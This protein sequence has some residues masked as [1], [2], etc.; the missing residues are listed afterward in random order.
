[1]MKKLK[2]F[3]NRWSGTLYLAFVDCLITMLAGGLAMLV[4]FEFSFNR[5][6]DEILAEWYRFIP[7]EL[8][9]TI[10]LFAV[11]G[12]YSYVLETLSALD[13]SKIALSCLV[14]SLS[15]GVVAAIMGVKLSVSIW[16]MMMSFKAVGCTSVRY[17]SR[18]SESLVS[19]IGIHREESPTRIMLV[20]AGAAGSNIMREIKSSNRQL[21]TVVCVIDDDPA[22]VGKEFYG[23][24]IVGGREAII[25]SSEKYKVDEIFIAVPSASRSER[26][27]LLSICNQTSC[28]V[29]T[30]P[31]IYQFINNEISIAALRDVSIQ[32]LLG[33]DQVELD[34]SEIYGFISGKKVVV[35]GAGGSIGS[36]LCRQIAQYDPNVLI[37]IDIYENSLYDIQQELK[38]TYGD[39][40]DFRA[41]IASIRDKDRIYSLFEEYSPDIVFHA[42]AHKHV[43]LMENAPEEAIKNNVFGTYHVVRAAEKF[44]VS[45]FI[46]I[47]TDKAVNPTN[48]MGATKRFC[49]MVLQSRQNSTTE[50]AS[51][52]FGNVLGSNGSVVPLF[53]K[54]IEE[55]GPV[56]ITDKRII[57]YFM[58]IPE[59]CS[60]VLEAGAMAKRNQVFILDMGDPVKIIDLAEEMIRLAGLRP[61]IDIPIVEIGL[62]PGEKLYEELLMS[63]DNLTKTANSKIFIEEQE[64]LSQDFIMSCL[65]EL[66]N[67]LENGVN[68][69]EAIALLMR[70]IPTYQPP[71]IVNSKVVLS[72][73]P[74]GQAHA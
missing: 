66:D 29:K 59:A 32:D 16:F 64:P 19:A 40:L 73:V 21:G 17:S 74:G 70:I 51:V 41:E 18:I 44:G 42:A 23:V 43:P 24:R 39:N 15:V 37:G 28:R 57:R 52:R 13:I 3:Y 1:M 47:S 36:E 67:A 27:E 48:I 54:Q 38:R 62:R 56:T 4:R 49:E 53:R 45:K 12:M 50:F 60:L 6:P 7:V 30:L 11:L 33:R 68:K 25:K 35:T 63:R 26:K 55:G 31:G 58:T 71:E 2:D 72:V 34:M 10:L 65:Q 9:I 20:G 8:V 5:V 61:Y 14:T 46:M 69:E 22:K